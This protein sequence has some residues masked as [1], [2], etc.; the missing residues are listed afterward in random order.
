MPADSKTIKKLIKLMQKEGVLKL[1]TQEIELELS[2]KAATPVLKTKLEVESPEPKSQQYS[3]EQIL[4]WS[5]P[6]FDSI[7]NAEN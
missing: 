7:P 5:A 2:P 3:E 1:K 4:M 6:G